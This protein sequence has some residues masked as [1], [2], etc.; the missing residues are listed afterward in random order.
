MSF[1]TTFG[2]Y[3]TTY[4]Q[5][6]DGTWTVVVEWDNPTSTCQ[7]HQQYLVNHR[8]EPL[9]RSLPMQRTINEICKDIERHKDDYQSLL[10][11]KEEVE[12]GNLNKIE[13]NYALESIGE[14]IEAI[15]HNS[16]KKQ[17]KSRFEED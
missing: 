10:Q 5:N 1:N 4:S 8:G 2:I 6:P 3:R 16:R 9:T 12:Q 13:Y 7:Y 17:I 15:N 14:K 11:L